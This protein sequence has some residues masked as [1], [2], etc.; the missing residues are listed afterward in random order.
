MQ[1]SIITKNCDDIALQIERII[2]EEDQEACF[3]S[4]IGLS[5]LANLD[6]MENQIVLWIDMRGNDLDG[7]KTMRDKKKQFSFC[8]FIWVDDDEKQAVDAYA[9]GADGFLLIPLENAKIAITL[10]NLKAN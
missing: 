4:T 8:K 5:Q 1:H 3:V 10:R 2:L 9:E 6:R 7:L